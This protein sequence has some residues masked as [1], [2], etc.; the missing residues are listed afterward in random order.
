MIIFTVLLWALLGLVGTGLVFWI[1]GAFIGA[2]QEREAV[3]YLAD[4]ARENR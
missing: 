2:S 1:V 4:K 3:E